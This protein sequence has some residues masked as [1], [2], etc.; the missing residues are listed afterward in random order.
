MLFFRG[1][2]LGITDVP[3]AW[4]IRTNA[5]YTAQNYIY[6][7]ETMPTDVQWVSQYAWPFFELLDGFWRCYLVNTTLPNG[8]EL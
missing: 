3:M 8:Y 2:K 4:G 1:L 5:I 6:H 7:W